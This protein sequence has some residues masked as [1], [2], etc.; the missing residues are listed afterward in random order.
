M[1]LIKTF[2]YEIGILN[3]GKL[4]ERSVRNKSYGEDN[5]EKLDGAAKEAK[6]R[7][8]ERLRIP[9]RRFDLV[10]KKRRTVVKQ[11]NNSP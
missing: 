8:N 11:I 4:Q 10:K 5:D 9:R 2:L 7:L 6:K 1:S 3:F